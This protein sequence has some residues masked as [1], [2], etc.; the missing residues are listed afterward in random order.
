M[1]TARV[2]VAYL[3][4]PDRLNAITFAMF[5]EFVT[6]QTQV[7]A[8]PTVRVLVLTGNGRGFC[9]GLDLDDAATL[10]DMPAAQMLR[11]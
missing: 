10:P 1:A 4:R 8:D 9:A 2:V 5:E 11:A 7:G 6:L 3:N